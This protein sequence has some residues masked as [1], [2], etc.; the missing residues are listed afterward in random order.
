MNG[1][2]T[3]LLQS[4]VLATT[5]HGFHYRLLNTILNSSSSS[6]SSYCAASTDLSDTL[7]PPVSIVYR[8]QE[9]FK[10]ISC[11]G[12]EL[13]YIG[14]SWLSCLCSSM[15]RGPQEYITYEFVLAS[16]AVSHMSGL[17][18][19]DSF[20][21]GWLVVVQLLFCGVLLSKFCCI[22]YLH[23]NLVHAC[24]IMCQDESDLSMRKGRLYAHRGILWCAGVWVHS[25]GSD[26]LPAQEW[27]C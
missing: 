2:W 9:I 20:H 18:N 27:L 10:A 12:T 7:S 8:F 17:S 24:Q 19:F 15:R 1:V 16:P 21:D 22:L 14:S 23:L 6:S 11:I 26:W 3:H 4:I 25:L 13:L 5:P